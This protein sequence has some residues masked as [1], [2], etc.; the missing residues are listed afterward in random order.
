MLLSITKDF[1]KRMRDL[2]HTGYIRKAPL[3]NY[4]PR[5]NEFIKST[6]VE[7]LPKSIHYLYKVHKIDI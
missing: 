4:N 2:M 6:G 7:A 5:F 1:K 3:N